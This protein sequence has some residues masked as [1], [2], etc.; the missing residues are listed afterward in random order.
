MFEISDLD[1][2]F[3]IGAALVWQGVD[4]SD[5]VIFTESGKVPSCQA[6][7]LVMPDGMGDAKDRDPAVERSQEVTC[8]F[9]FERYRHDVVGGVVNEHQDVFV[10]LTWG[11][12]HCQVHTNKLSRFRIM[13]KSGE[14]VLRPGVI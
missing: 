10:P 14:F 13:G 5:R 6:K 12:I 2:R 4:L 11:K 3:A 7:F 9:R 1:F 8:P